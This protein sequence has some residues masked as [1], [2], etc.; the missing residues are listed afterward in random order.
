MLWEEYKK[1]SDLYKAK[2]FGITQF[3]LFTTNFI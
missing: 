1:K 3:I 2:T